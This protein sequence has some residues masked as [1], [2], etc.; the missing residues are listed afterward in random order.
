MFC[1]WKE[2]SDAWLRHNVTILR[3]PFEQAA[4]QARGRRR[5]SHREPPPHLHGGE[6]LEDDARQLPLLALR[7]AGHAGAG[8]GHRLRAP[9][10]RRSPE[11]DRG[12]GCKALRRVRRERR[13]PWQTA[14]NRP[15]PPALHAHDSL[16][17]R[18]RL[19]GACT[20]RPPERARHAQA[21]CAMRAVRCRASG[22]RRDRRSTCGRF[23]PGAGPRKGRSGR[24]G[25]HRACGGPCASR[26]GPA[27]RS[28]LAVPDA[29]Q[30]KGSCSAV[31]CGAPQAGHVARP[32]KSRR[33]QHT[34]AAIPQAL[35][36]VP[37]A[38]LAFGAVPP[39]KSLV[40]SPAARW[41]AT[42]ASRT[43]GQL[44]AAP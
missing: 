26:A 19:W 1:L 30:T 4:D 24:G 40:C 31:R 16:G 28:P 18:M 37:A 27:A 34:P 35:N 9:P 6:G 21:P 10:R 42:H 11:W 43:R 29:R 38:P 13:R 2:G 12:G 36:T 23:P 15:Q 8:L 7:A 39:C 32:G 20:G 44:I 33:L 5:S 41:A 25:R 17:Q 14:V 3:S 22:A